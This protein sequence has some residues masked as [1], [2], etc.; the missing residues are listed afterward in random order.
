MSKMSLGSV[1]WQNIWSKCYIHQMKI[2]IC[3]FKSWKITKKCVI[4]KQEIYVNEPILKHK[5][6]I[7]PF[8]SCSVEH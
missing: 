5:F 3:I 8:K 7:N 2:Y 1:I 6:C 4:S